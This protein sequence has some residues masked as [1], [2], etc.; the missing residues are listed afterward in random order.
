MSD[1]TPSLEHVHFPNES[2]EYRQARNALLAEEIALRRQV[3]RVAALRR[4]LP[5]GGRIREDYVFVGEG[6]PVRMSALFSAGHDT[7]A[8]YSYMFGP[9]RER[10]CP[11]CTHFLDALDGQMDHIQQRLDLIVVAKS[12]YPR[13]AGFAT[14]RGWRKLRLLSTDGNTYDRDY[15]GDTSGLSAELR[16]QQQFPNGEDWDMPVLNLFQRR[17]KEIRHF[18]VGTAL[19]ADRSGPGLAPD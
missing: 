18:W 7:L 15:Y 12:P 9:D 17:G 16:R 2:D 4:A 14:A 1:R 8:V 10:P 19:R 6:G 3:E 5:E 11:G 13:I